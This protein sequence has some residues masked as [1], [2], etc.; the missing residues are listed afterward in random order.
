MGILLIIGFILFIVL[1]LALDIHVFRRGAD[2]ESVPHAVG[3]SVFWILL[4]LAFNLLVYFTY[5]HHWFGMGKEIG[6]SV[7][8]ITAALQFL[9][10][11]LLEKSLSV[12]NIFLIAM[13]FA[14][15]RIPLEKQHR[16]LVWGIIGIVIMRGVM[17]SL[18]SPLVSRFGWLMYV[19]GALLLASAAKLLVSDYGDPHPDRSVFVRL[20]RKLY[21]VTTGMT[22]SE[23]FINEDGRRAASPLFVA[24]LLVGGVDLLF[25]IDSIPAICTITNDRFIVFTSNAFAV[26]GLHSL[27]FVLAAVMQ[28]FRY[29]KMSMFF[30]LIFI[31]IKAVFAHYR[32]IS[33]PVS[34]LVI[35]GILTVGVIASL[36]GRRAPERRRITGRCLDHEY[37]A[38]LTRASIIRIIILVIGSTAAVLIAV[39]IVLRFP[40]FAIAML[41]A[42]LMLPEILWAWRLIRHARASAESRS[43][44]EPDEKGEGNA[45]GA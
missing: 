40:P 20:L 10:G 17:I 28:K 43:C 30:M 29:M 33:A 2:V 16:V 5:E 22:G 8:G 15:L 13:I 38:S 27:Y 34:L 6:S 45:E 3:W 39:V 44:A 23:F 9:T 41:F 11:F 7:S 4:A 25:A 36:F 31:G 35:G 19:F 42:A 18:G 1:M 21:P 37:L 32:P 26:L 12:D 14:S 24:L